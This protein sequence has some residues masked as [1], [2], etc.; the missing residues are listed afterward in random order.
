MKKVG[1][2]KIQKLINNIK[3]RYQQKT[4]RRDKAGNFFQKVK[5]GLSYICTI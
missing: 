2:K 3:K 4:E 1:I 5:I